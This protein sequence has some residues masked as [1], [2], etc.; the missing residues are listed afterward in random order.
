[1]YILVGIYIT[2]NQFQMLVVP[3]NMTAKQAPKVE[4]MIVYQKDNNKLYVQSDGKLN[5]L[6][7]EKVLSLYHTFPVPCFPEPSLVSCVKQRA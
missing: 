3:N 6:A 5:A 7:E 4:G 1:M 2:N